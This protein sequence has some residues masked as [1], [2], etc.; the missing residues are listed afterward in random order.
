[1]VHMDILKTSLQTPK[2]NSL[3]NNFPHLQSLDTNVLYKNKLSNQCV[4]LLL[5]KAARLVACYTPIDKMYRAP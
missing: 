1:M 2:N 4:K 5:K 3:L